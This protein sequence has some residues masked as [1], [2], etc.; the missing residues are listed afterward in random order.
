MSTGRNPRICI[1]AIAAFVIALALGA[2]LARGE[3]WPRWRGPRGDGISTE[4]GLLETW[5]RTFRPLWTAEVGQG[6]SSP[7]A[8]A[9]RVYCF[10][11]I[12]RKD[13]L[14]CY[15]ATKGNVIWSKTYDGGWTGSY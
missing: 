12:D 6:Y 11:L 15:D 3:D 7:V 13:T 1:V 10:S 4:T 9:G 2:P 14:T 8:Q 5:P